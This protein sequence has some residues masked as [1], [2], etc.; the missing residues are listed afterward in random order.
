MEAISRPVLK[1]LR[2]MSIA[3][4]VEGRV[5]NGMVFNA[6][7]DRKL[8][9]LCKWFLAAQTAGMLNPVCSSADVNRLLLSRLSLRRF[10]SGAAIH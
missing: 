8:A 6:C 10:V 4:V 7:R 5:W 2:C 9:S 1:M 3:L